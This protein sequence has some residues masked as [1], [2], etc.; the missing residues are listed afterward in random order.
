[1]RERVEIVGEG[2]AT[3]RRRRLLHA[4]APARR[5][6]RSPRA[7]RWCAAGGC[8]AAATVSGSPAPPPTEGCTSVAAAR[9]SPPV[10]PLHPHLVADLTAVAAPDRRRRRFSSTPELRDGISPPPWRSR[11]STAADWNGSGRAKEGLAA[12]GMRSGR[13]CRVHDHSRLSRQYTLILI[14]L[15]AASNSARCLLPTWRRELVL[16]SS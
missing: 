14:V 7:A 11:S 8:L 4:V 2:A 5:R 16:P 9:T 15:F 3:E 13:R 12:V 6:C 1:M 10:S